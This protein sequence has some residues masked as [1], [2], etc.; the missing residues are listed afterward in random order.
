[1]LCL[2]WG[3]TWLAIRIQ[4][5]DFPPLRAAALRFLLAAAFIA[6]WTGRARE[7]TSAAPGPFFRLRLAVLLVALPYACVYWGEQ[8][9]PSGLTAV[10]FATYPL[11]VALLAHAGVPGERF[12]LPLAIGVGCGLAGV[13]VLFRSEIH[14]NGPHALTGAGLILIAA[15]SSAMST[16]M[17]RRHLG[18][19]DPRR[20]HLPPMLY[21]GLLLLGVS[22]VMEQSAP[23][24][25]GLRGLAALVYLALF[26]SAIAFA[27]YFW[28]MRSISV[29]RLSF[30]VYVTPLVALMLG[31]VLAE[32]AM[33]WDVAMGT[34]LVISGVAVARRRSR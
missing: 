22:L 34:A 9:I 23:W 5:Q 32:E 17:V 19:M 2:I 11:F 10:L 16:V 7:Q 33:T 13:A 20:I 31:A 14:G 6:L 1:M 18:H 15:L 12:T 3:S 24:S 21:G 26:G 29:S 28:L 25:W 8:F 30:V 4:V 27:L